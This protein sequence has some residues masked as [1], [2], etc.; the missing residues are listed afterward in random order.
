MAS[1]ALETNA[2]QAGVLGEEENVHRQIALAD[3]RLCEALKRRETKDFC[4]PVIRRLI[5]LVANADRIAEEEWNQ[6]CQSALRTP[7]VTF[8]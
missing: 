3:W 5:D 7:G 4:G 6:R 1:S 8:V 2:E